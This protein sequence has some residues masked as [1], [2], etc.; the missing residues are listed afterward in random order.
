MGRHRSK[1]GARAGDRVGGKSLALKVLYGL[2]VVVFGNTTQPESAAVFIG[3]QSMCDLA[4]M[5]IKECYG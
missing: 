5:T 3:G 1:N 4:S 2:G